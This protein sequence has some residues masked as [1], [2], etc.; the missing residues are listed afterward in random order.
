MNPL[1]NGF[2]IHAFKQFHV[3]IQNNPNKLNGG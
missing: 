2:V 1:V 3:F